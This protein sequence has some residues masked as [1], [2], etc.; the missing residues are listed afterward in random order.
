MQARSDR[1]EWLALVTEPVLE[2]DLPICDAHHHLWLDNGHSGFPY[3]VPSFHADTG[4]GHNVIHSVFLECNAEYYTDGPEQLRPVGETAFVVRCAAE[5]RQAGGTE[6]AAIMGHADVM[7]GDAVEEVLAAHEA[8]GAGLFRGIR[9]IVAWDADRKLQMGIPQGALADERLRAGVRTVGRLGH[10]FDTMIYHPQLPELTAMA[11]ACPETTIVADHLCPPL[12]VGPYLDRRDEVLPQ[13]RRDM[14]ELAS[15]P[16]VRL[17]LGGIGMPMYGLRWDKGELPPT[18][19]QLAAPWR[20]E[21]LHLIDA[22]GPDRCLFESNF[23]MDKRG[24][25]Y[26]VLWNTFKRIAAGFSAAEKRD[27]FHD[28]AART[29][30]I[31]TL[32]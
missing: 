9:Y 19:E 8:A 13:W 2:P 22:F 14:T 3:P 20:D 26:L 25:S 23:P 1:S 15:C 17:K 16:N 4:S 11:R 7:L 32:A 24:C 31:A 10:T 18:S 12:G 5:A 29:Y 27:L 6:I 21:F 30:R 28:T